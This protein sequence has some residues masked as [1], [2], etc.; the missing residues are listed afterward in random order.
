MR[1]STIISLSAAAECLLCFLKRKLSVVVDL[2][3]MGHGEYGLALKRLLFWAEFID[4][5]QESS[6]ESIFIREVCVLNGISFFFF[7]IFI[8]F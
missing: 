6:Q 1:L 2:E 8:Y 5:C 4:R 3:H 7:F